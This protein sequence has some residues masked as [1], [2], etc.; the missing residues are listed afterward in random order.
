MESS[1]T[2]LAD[3]RKYQR[4]LSALHRDIDPE[5]YLEIGC[6]KGHSLALARKNVVGVD[7]NFKLQ[8]DVLKDREQCLLYQ[9]ESDRFFD[10]EILKSMGVKPDLA[11]LDGMHL[12]EFL[13]RDFINTEHTCHSGSVIALHD[14]CPRTHEMASRERIT[15][16]W[17]GDVWKVLV[18]LLRERPDLD[19]KVYDARATGLVVIS[20]LDPGNTKLKQDY[21][22]LYKEFREVELSEFGFENFYSL[23]KF[24]SAEDLVFPKQKTSTD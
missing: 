3:G 19:I 21:E 15:R 2:P 8:V 17:T 13:L 1:R 20:N 24:E 10:Q 14:C 9:M 23:F 6:H 12:F 16:D 5:W 11:F 4:V 7:P 18:I 22:R